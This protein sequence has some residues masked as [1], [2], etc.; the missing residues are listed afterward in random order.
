MACSLY[1]AVMAW[2]LPG[3]A[4]YYN[5]TGQPRTFGELRAR[6]LCTSGELAKGTCNYDARERP[7]VAARRA[8]IPD[9]GWQQGTPG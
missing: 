2:I 1:L 4:G 3:A 9:E 7:N 5:C 6:W 8:L